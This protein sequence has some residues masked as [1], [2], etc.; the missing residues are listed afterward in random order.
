MGAG[1]GT[2]LRPL[3]DKQ[4][5]PLLEI[6]GK[7]MIVYVF[8]RLVRSGIRRFIVNTHH[9]AGCWKEVFPESTWQ[10]LP[11]HFVHEEI[12]LG[13]GGGLKNI[14]PLVGCEPLLLHSGDVVTNIPLD[15]LFT[16]HG[17]SGAEVTL[18]LRSNPGTETVALG[19]NQ[20]ITYI[21]KALP[22]HSAADT[23]YDYANVAVI[24]PSFFRR[25]PD[26]HP[27]GIAEI[28]ASMI[29]EKKSLLGCVLNE[30]YWYN[31]GTPEEYERI[32]TL[33]L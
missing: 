23:W 21:G 25:I 29:P 27:R 3:T 28:W 6:Q 5:K 9:A 15:P 1:L 24:E 17:L 18:A 16:S 31:V 10:N 7:P 11:L 12:L 32:Q 33:P 4:P 26:T 2:R 30:G 19:K 22:D 20:S 14:E 13:T 8:E